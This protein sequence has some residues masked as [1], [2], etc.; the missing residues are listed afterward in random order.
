MLQQP[1]LQ[2]PHML[3]VWRERYRR[4]PDGWLAELGSRLCLHRYLEVVST[5]MPRGRRSLGIHQLI[6]GGACQRL[7]AA[8]RH[9]SSH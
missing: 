8:P 1:L 5:L 9:F 7:M 3:L 4:G 2:S 6:V